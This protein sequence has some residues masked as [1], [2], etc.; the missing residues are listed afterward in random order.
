MNDEVQQNIGRQRRL[1]N[2]GGDQ[3]VFHDIGAIFH[4]FAEPLPG[5]ACGKN[6]TGGD[7]MG[8][9]LE[10]KCPSWTKQYFLKSSPLDI[11]QLSQIA[12]ASDIY[13]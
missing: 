8:Y 7:R 4:A 1:S 3:V 13:S 11:L 12:Q 9:F 10:K 6:T 5:G 2:S